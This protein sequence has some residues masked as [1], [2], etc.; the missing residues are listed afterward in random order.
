MDETDIF[1]CP[2]LQEGLPRG[3]VEAMSRGC[4]SLGAVTGGIPELLGDAYLHSK[5]DWRKLAGQ[6]VRLTQHPEE[7]QQCARDNFAVASTFSKE[8]L[9]QKRF[10]F[11]KAYAQE[12][13]Q[14][15]AK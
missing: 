3:L 11:W 5:K 14:S 1:L 13:E 7:M 12:V 10:A 15:L 9:D 8:V 2:S 4:P 6:I